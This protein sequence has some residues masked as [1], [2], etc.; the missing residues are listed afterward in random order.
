MDPEACTLKTGQG[1]PTLLGVGAPGA[2]AVAPRTGAVSTCT[3][4][5]TLL[6][7]AVS[8]ITNKPPLFL[9]NSLFPASTQFSL[10]LSRNGALPRLGVGEGRLA[11]LPSLPVL[12]LS[13]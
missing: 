9:M 5:G 8:L 6:G 2:L 12:F 10:L 4:E 3:G 11:L 13:G 1:C 7:E